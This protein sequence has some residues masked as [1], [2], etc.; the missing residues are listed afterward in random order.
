MKKNEHKYVFVKYSAD[1]PYLPEVVADNLEE[2]AEKLGTTYNS[3]KS[4][5]YHQRAGFKK[6]DISED[7][8]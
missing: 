4:S 7:C 3:V 5:V 8:I 1:P 6:I 2:L